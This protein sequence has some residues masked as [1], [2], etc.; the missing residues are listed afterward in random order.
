VFVIKAMVCLLDPVGAGRR[1][2]LTMNR[3]PGD[4]LMPFISVKLPPEAFR[5]TAILK[6]TSD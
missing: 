3:I 4:S 1:P 2:A 5:P 6:S